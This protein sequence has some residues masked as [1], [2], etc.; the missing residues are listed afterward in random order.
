LFYVSMLRMEWERLTKRDRRRLWK[1][2]PLLEITLKHLIE[3]GHLEDDEPSD[4]IRE[5][6]GAQVENAARLE[7]DGLEARI[8]FQRE[9]W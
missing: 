3:D 5:H 9:P 6:A 4:E 2:H 1:R 8:G 7:V